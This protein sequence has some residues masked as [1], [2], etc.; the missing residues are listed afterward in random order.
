[1]D[2]YLIRITDTV[3]FYATTAPEF[4][5][6]TGTSSYDTLLTLFTIGGEPLYYNDDGPG[7]SNFRSYISDPST[8]PGGEVNASA[9]GGPTVV[10]GDYILAITSYNGDPTDGG[11]VPLFVRPGDNGDPYTSLYGESP[12]AGPGAA[13]RGNEEGTY[14]IELG[15]ATFVP[16]P[17]SA[18]LGLLGLTVALRRRR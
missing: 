9:I 13:W 12:L 18:L 1:M 3:G 8:F 7:A 11:D 10:P 15:G 16:E 17:G 4:G 6:G 5:N 2:A 14:T